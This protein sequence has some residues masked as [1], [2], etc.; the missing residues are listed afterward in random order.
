[1]GLILFLT[2]LAVAEGVSA[3]L[4]CVK[5]G[6]NFPHFRNWLD[7]NELQDLLSEKNWF[8]RGS[9]ING[10]KG[11]NKQ[12]RKFYIVEHQLNNKS[13]KFNY[14]WN[15]E[16]ISVWTQQYP[17]LSEIICFES[18]HSGYLVI[19]TTNLIQ[20]STETLE[21]LSAE[22]REQLYLRL[23]LSL[24]NLEDQRLFFIN[25]TAAEEKLVYKTSSAVLTSLTL[26]DIYATDDKFR[27][28]FVLNFHGICEEGTKVRMRENENNPPEVTQAINKI[29]RSEP[30]KAFSSVEGARAM[31]LHRAKTMTNKELRK[32]QNVPLELFTKASIY[33]NGWWYITNV[34]V[35]H[36]MFTKTAIDKSRQKNIFMNLMKL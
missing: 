5:D 4:Y 22:E 31:K 2:T 20:L 10:F 21:P 30:L 19:E 29:L 15:K 34:I 33:W 36:E 35:I 9:W 23:G 18:S 1:M 28:L 14:D 7:K 3:T 27:T 32:V 13:I 12:G 17:S 16:F 24:Q 8:W 25:G 6:A 26:N 11:G